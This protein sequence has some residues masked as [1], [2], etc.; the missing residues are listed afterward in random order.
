MAKAGVTIDLNPEDLEPIRL[1]FREYA[2]WLGIDLGFQG[3]EA[4]LAGLPGAYA[5]PAGRMWLAHRAGHPLAAV[6]VRPESPGAC[7]MKRLWVREEARRLGLGKYLVEE[8]LAFGRTA[9]YQRMR[10]DTLETMGPALRL[11]ERAGFRRITAY[12][13]NP[14]PDVVY[15]ERDLQH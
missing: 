12:Y 15:L 6:A 11:Y 1:L 2:A 9:G 13:P 3:F 5:P 7:E 8:T 10:L 4:E 14:H